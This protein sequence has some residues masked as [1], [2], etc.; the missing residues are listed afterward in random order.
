MSLNR[1]NCLFT[2]TL[3]ELL[4]AELAED[5]ESFGCAEW[6][7]SKMPLARRPAD[8]DGKNQ[9]EHPARAGTPV[10]HENL[11]HSLL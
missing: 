3:L 9:W 10:R 8:K 2:G 5:L 6:H 7:K 1:P 11:D 4:I